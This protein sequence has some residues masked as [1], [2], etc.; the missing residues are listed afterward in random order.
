MNR[1]IFD[2][3]SELLR[4][5]ERGALITIVNTVGS[6]PRKAGAKMLVTEDGRLIGTVGGGCVEADLVAYAKRVIR[7]GEPELH[8]I[9]LTAKSADKNDMLCGGKMKAFIDPIV[10][11]EKLVI[12]GGGHISR[13]LHDLAWRLGF[14]VVVTDDREQFANK[15]RFPH[16]S[17]ILAESYERQ[18][19]HIQFDAAT[20]IVIATRGHEYDELCLE[21]SLRQPCRY[22]A[23]VGSKTKVALFKA[24]LREKGFTE[25]ELARVVCPAGLD[26]GAETPEEIALSIAAQMVAVRRRGKVFPIGA[27]TDSKNQPL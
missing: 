5:G 25:E 1:D 27:S 18:F 20:Y 23:M 3:I 2:A 14:R 6:T 26:I 10:A 7:T 12:F 13:A 4:S 22:L 19:E 8:E 21:K 9:D 16:A 11:E 17:E 24:R 15:E